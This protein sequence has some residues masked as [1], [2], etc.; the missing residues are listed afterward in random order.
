MLVLLLGFGLVMA[1]TGNA[2]VRAGLELAN[3]KGLVPDND[4]LRAGRL[5]GTLERL[6]IVGF[7]VAGQLTAAALVISAK[8]LLRFRELDEKQHSEY[9][10]VGSLLSWTVALTAVALFS[11]AGG[12]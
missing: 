1:S 11:M 7:A 3:A 5:I 4:T 9:V 10:L 6:L 12:S 2:L 8:G